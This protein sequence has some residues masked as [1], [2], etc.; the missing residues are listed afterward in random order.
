MLKYNLLKASKKTYSLSKIIFFTMCAITYSTKVSGQETLAHKLGYA[1]NT[2]LLIIHADDLG[3]SHTEN[4]A[5][6]K[7]IEEG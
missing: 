6:I 4:T 3:F 5:S 2:K 7:A 1:S